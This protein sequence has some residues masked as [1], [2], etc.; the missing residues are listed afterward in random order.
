MQGESLQQKE[1]R[2]LLSRLH[3][4]NSSLQDWKLLLQCSPDIVSNTAQFE[5]ATRLFYTNK[6]VA[7][8]NYEQLKNPKNP[9]ACIQARHSSAYAKKRTAEDMNGLQP[10]L[11]LAKN[12]KVI[13]TMN[14]RPTV[15][16]CNGATGT[17]VDFI[18]HNNSQPPSLPIAVV[19]Q[20]DDYEGPS[21]FLMINQTVF[22]YVQL[23][24]HCKYLKVVMNADN[25]P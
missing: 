8:Y 3:T 12:S 25:C 10:T 24:S 13:L 6:D 7:D 1:F 4:G 22:Q 11:F 18:Y 5:N 19:V 16:L 20:F 9:I 23:L 17:V 14:L 15:G 21:I 2:D